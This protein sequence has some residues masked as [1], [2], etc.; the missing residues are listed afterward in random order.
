MTQDKKQQDNAV[1]NGNSPASDKSISRKE[2]VRLVLKRGAVAGAIV[3]AP[4]I[5]DKFL[6]PPVY[7]ESSTTVQ[8]H[9][10]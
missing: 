7:A 4:Q 3:A 9:L 2:F 5:I 1:T 8:G 10:T 6:V